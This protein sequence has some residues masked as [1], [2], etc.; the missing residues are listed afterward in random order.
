MK[1]VFLLL[2]KEIFFKSIF[3]NAALNR[4]GQA[5]K[6]YDPILGY[7]TTFVR[8]FIHTVLSQCLREHGELY[9]VPWDVEKEEKDMEPRISS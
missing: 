1:N 9:F 4:I 2:L 7:T 5:N 6:D 3:D 8:Q